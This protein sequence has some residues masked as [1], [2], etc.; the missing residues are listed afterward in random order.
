MKASRKTALAAAA[1]AAVLLGRSAYATVLTWDADGIAPIDG[2]T[3][4]WDTTSAKWHNGVSY[5]NWANSATDD[6]VFGTTTT[7]SAVITIDAAVNQA[8]TIKFNDSYT[9]NGTTAI[10]L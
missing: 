7:V 8:A 9:L 1:V 6:A 4:T 2:G 5:T 10:T 3:G